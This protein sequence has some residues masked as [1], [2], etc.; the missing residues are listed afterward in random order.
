MTSAQQPALLRTAGGIPTEHRMRRLRQS[1]GLRRM[2]RETRLS[3][4]DFIYPV[5]VTVG[6][7][8]REPIP[9]MPGQSRLSVDQLAQEAAELRSLDI[10]AILLF[11]IP[12]S[13]DPQGSGAWIPD[14]IIQQAV[15][16]LK[17]AQPDLIVVTDV[18]L[19]EYTDHGHCGVLADD[20][21]VIN[22]DS[23]ELLAQTAV[24][25]AEAGADVIAPSDM[26]DGRIGVI[27]QALDQGGFDDRTLLA[28]SAK[29]ASAF[30]GPFRD[31]ADSA[32][33]FG[34]R[35]AY[36]MDP[37]NGREAMR[38]IERDLAEGAD[39]VMVKPALA[40]LDLVHEARQRFDAPLAAYNVSGE[41]AMLKAAAANG[42]IDEERV[43]LET[44]TGIRR[45]GADLILT[46]H[47]KE[48]S[49]W[50]ARAGG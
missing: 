39:M 12:E 42:W 29:F 2:V 24:S 48:A 10:P 3:P 27:R 1:D 16:A 20:G 15:R 13:K 11:G 26:M 50:L 14:G 28:Y 32:P 21:S 25:Q 23:V 43:V 47:A 44:L 8:V 31:A 49:R 30:Y 45:A 46:Y 17:D 37:P 41:Y 18:C 7:D 40:Y 19:C 4:T 38:A 22:D 36:Q 34:D 35:R 9:S 6:R 5:F 33:Q